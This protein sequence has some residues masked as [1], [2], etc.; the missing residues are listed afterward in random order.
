MLVL[1]SLLCLC[2]LSIAWASLSGR[3]VV[4]LYPF[5][6]AQVTD[7]RPCHGLDPKT[8]QP[9]DMTEPFSTRDDHLEVCGH[10]QVSYFG[11]GGFPVPLS[12]LWRYEEET[13]YLSDTR[14]YSP[15]YITDLWK[16]ES[17]QQLRPGTYQV[18]VYNGRSLLASGRI[19]V[20]PKS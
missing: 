6:R 9:T 18:E 10:L 20:V 19:I 2:S 15:G 1:T 8:E 3:M 17:G 7:M 4:D 16:P 5:Y 14:M 11:S 13:V 12:F